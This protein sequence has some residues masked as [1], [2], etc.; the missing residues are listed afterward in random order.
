MR[1]AFAAFALA[2]AACSASAPLGPALQPEGASGVSDKAL[3]HFTREA[4]VAAHPL[5]AEAGARMLREG[6]SAL[7]AAVA[8]QMV[9]GLVEPQSSG[10]GG[11]AFLLH[12]DGARVRAYDGRET[13]PASVD[14]TLFLDAR[15]APLAFAAAAIGGRA[16]GVPGLLR[17]LELAHRAHGRLPWARLF[18]PAITL[19]EDGFAVGPRLALLLEGDAALRRD[20]LA[21]AL[22]YRADGS[23]VAVGSRL[24]NPEYAALLRLIARQGAS[25][26]YEGPVAVA[27]VNAV[28]GHT[29]NPGRLAVADLAA[30]RALE[31]EPLCHDWRRFRICG[32]PPPSS[33]ALV[34]GQILGV[35]ERLP[36]RGPE[37]SQDTPSADFVHRFSQAARLAYA[38]REHH[39]ADPDR[40]TAPLGRWDS[41]LD[42][43]YLDAR[44]RLI[45][46]NAL[47]EAPPGQPGRSAAGPGAVRALSAELPATTHLSIVDAAGNA[48]ALT[49]SIEAQFGARL[50]VNRGVGLAGGF[51]LNNQLTDFSFAPRTADGATAANRAEPGKRPRSSM[52]PTFAFEHEARA[53]LRLVLVAGSPG[54]VPIPLYVA[55]T[56]WAT[57]AWGLDVQAAVA[58]PNFGA[59][60][61][62]TLL[63]AGRFSRTDVAELRARGHSVVETALTSGAHLLRRE[64]TG[65]QAGADPRREGVAA[66]R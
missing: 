30:Y 18:E 8:A 41:L 50:M 58:L 45:G 26:L 52:A 11:G 4:V 53:P 13:A 12:W 66:G 59:L 51:L 16:V 64:A 9:L 22:Y 32:M 7:D 5:A 54:G 43:D 24:R 15:A 61:G 37:H 63:E 44:A 17:M 60:T 48:V 28:R 46:P 31:R 55:K 36:A 23:A 56:L 1:F 42:A 34:V 19:A 38:D 39:V 33:G 2:L 40:S 20:P 21:R 27:I 25:A 35:L 3:G 6:G 14:D 65:W 62:P 29:D 10:I 47:R 49:S 57:L